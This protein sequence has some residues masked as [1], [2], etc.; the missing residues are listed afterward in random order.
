[1]K[2]YCPHCKKLADLNPTNM[3]R[4]FCSEKCKLID[5]GTWAREEKLISRPVES[6]DYFQD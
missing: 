6:E 4:P 3:Y 5:L 2:N 1:M